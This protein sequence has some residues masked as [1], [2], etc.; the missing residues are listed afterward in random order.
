MGSQWFKSREGTTSS[1]MSRKTKELH[2][3]VRYSQKEATATLVV[4][5]MP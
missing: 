3:N 4:A 2:R 1:P 5:D